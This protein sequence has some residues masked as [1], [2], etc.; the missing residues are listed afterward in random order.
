[1]YPLEYDEPVFRPPSERQS[2]ILQVT[3]GCSWNQCTFCNMYQEKKFQTKP[4]DV[5]DSELK[6]IA[7]HGYTVRRV[8]LADGD[9][10]SLST[11]RLKAILKSIKQ[12]FP[13]VQRISSYCLP[14]NL[15]KKSVQ[16]LSELKALGLSL[17]YV[18]CETGDDELLD[19]IDKGESYHSSLSALLKMKKAGLK[20]SVMIL[21]GL[22]G[23]TLSEQ[24]VKNSV[25]LV[26]ATQP[27]Y[28]SSLVVNFPANGE[29]RFAKNFDGRWLAMQQEELFAELHAMISAFQLK[30]TIFRADHIS[31]TL[32]LK[33]V[34]GKDQDTMLEQIE[35][36]IN[37]PQ[38][39]PLRPQRKR[40]LY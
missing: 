25:A 17:L 13:N 21:N 31:N 29:A 16:D 8:F 23:V 19:I 18:G 26:N 24:H 11:R 32:V 40:L 3:T 9:A 15:A 35:L 38:M 7:E 1:M 14:R 20:S 12:H 28:L 37:K 39:V 2:L 6:R 27:D 10:M 34:L 30:K 22:G 33:G 4:I 5:I 36:A